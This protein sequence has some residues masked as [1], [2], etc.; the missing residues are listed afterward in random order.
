[1]CGICGIY[2]IER[3][4]PA[5]REDLESMLSVMRHRGP[6][7]EGLHI[8]RNIALGNRRL[9]IID[10]KGGKQPIFNEE[11]T[12]S[13][14]HNG[15]IYNFRELRAELENKGHKF[16]TASD[17]EVLLHLYEEEGVDMLSRLNGIFAFAIFDETRRELFIA[18]DRIGAKPLYYCQ[19]KDRFLFS[20]EIKSLLLLDDIPREPDFLA[21]DMLLSF[22]WIPE[23]RTGFESI[24]RLEPGSYLILRP[25]GYPIRNQYWD[26]KPSKKKPRSL[27]ES[28][29][30]LRAILKRAVK[31]QL[32]SEAPV[33]AFLSGGL[34]SSGLAFYMKES[35]EKEQRFY[36]AFWS[37]EEAKLDYQ[38]RDI[39]YARL[40]A[41]GFNLRTEEIRLHPP[42]L[43][44]LAKIVWFIEQ[45]SGVPAILPA[46]FIS[47]A[48]SRSSTVLL[49]GMGAD[50]LFAGYPRHL[51]MKLVPYFNLL[52]RPLKN[53]VLSPLLDALSL[54][55]AGNFKPLLRRAKRTLPYLDQPFHKRYASFFIHLSDE[56]RKAL[57]TPQM[58]ARLEN[59]DPAAPFF[60]AFYRDT[61]RDELDSLLYVD[62]KVYLPGDNLLYT[63]KMGMAHS[64]EV[65]VPYL[66][67]E[68]IDFAASLD[69]S[70]KLNG[71]RGK[72]VLRRAMVGILP[73]EIINR[74]KAGFTAPVRAW[75]R[76]RGE[77]LHTLF[78]DGAI[79]K[80]KIFE[81]AA[82]NR[83]IS[84]ELSGRDDYGISL[85]AF[86]MLE[87]WFRT[88]IDR[89][90]KEL[91]EP[92]KINEYKNH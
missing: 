9:S 44:E 64:I 89:P 28:A 14:I 53:R 25:N 72:E 73:R 20:S 57:Y 46:Y 29:E 59:S 83:L 69:P 8:S 31:R 81:P 85:W 11:R 17:T 37:K 30:E 56:R 74:R 63:D 6:D 41:K 45:P 75:L 16:Q 18:R 40:V 5:N 67:N 13:V 77:L 51:A 60:S 10:I 22:M 39:E 42:S 78:S 49:S 21:L 58:R 24:R 87:L 65:R 70:C 27:D 66:D 48:A 80:R 19:T 62:F 50:E 91:V 61:F 68:M 79:K 26:F 82:L 15:E 35:A 3:D 88:F 23:P 12:L 86:V 33:G 92:L 47:Q 2:N 54:R 38:P 76:N 7:D 84:D 43:D 36:A 32:I 4:A 71:L 90:R 55:G 1:M 34:D 52:P